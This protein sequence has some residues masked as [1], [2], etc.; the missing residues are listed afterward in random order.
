MDLK[1]YKL[2]R[3]DDR[4]N[5]QEMV[6]SPDGDYL[7]KADVEPLL[8]AYYAMVTKLRFYA[9]DVRDN[10]EYRI[11]NSLEYIKLMDIP[12]EEIPLHINNYDTDSYQHLILSCRLSG[13]DPVKKD[14]AKCITLLWDVSF[15]SEAYK[16]IG[17]NDGLASAT[18]SLLDEAGLK[19]ES[20][21]VLDATYSSD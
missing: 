12:D 16:N 11:Q 6:E 17:Y 10:M 3:T 18:S 5:D 9:N 1:A 20:I 21:R 13:E 14:L 4:F 15:D 2:I 19:E 8:K 7:L